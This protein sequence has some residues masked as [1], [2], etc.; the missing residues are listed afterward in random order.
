LLRRRPDIIEAE[1][2]LAQL[3]AEVGVAKK[4]FLPMLSLT[5]SIGTSANK[6]DN[7]FGSPSL[8]YSIGPSLSWTVF[9]GF[10]R[11]NNVAQARLQLEAATDDYNMTVLT[12]LEEVENAISDYNA[13]LANVS[14]LEKAV[15]ESKHSY[16]LAVD[17]YRD[18]LSDFINV[19]NSQLTYLENQNSLA[20]ANGK[21]YAAQVALYEALGGGSTVDR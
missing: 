18:G 9:D 16:T 21:V 14:L 10:T 4:D 19:N 5:G 3:A 11:K 13:A 6:F 20:S 8:E 7:L 12:A 15:E 1:M 17:L 2:Q